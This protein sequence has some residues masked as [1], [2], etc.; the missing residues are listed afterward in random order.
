MVGMV[1]DN[2]AN[3]D[4][5]AAEHDAAAD[6]GKSHGIWSSWDCIGDDDEGNPKE[7]L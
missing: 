4:A 3:A 6:D 1:D 7:D 2:D 5:D